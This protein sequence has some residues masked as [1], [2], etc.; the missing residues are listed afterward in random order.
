MICSVLFRFCFFNKSA[1]KSARLFLTA[2]LVFVLLFCISTPVVSAEKDTQVNSVDSVNLRDNQ[3][4]YSIYVAKNGNK[5]AAITRYDGGD[6]DIEIPSEL[7]GVPVK[8]ISRE[9]FCNGKYITSVA[10]PE[11]VTE[12]GKY[13]FS[14]CIGLSRVTFPESL[15]SV[16][17]GAF[18][19]CRSLKSA[20]FSE[21]L[22][23]IGSFAFYGCVHLTGAS[24]P[25]TLRSIGNSAFQGCCMLENVSFGSGLEIIGDTAFMGCASISG[26]DLSGINDLGAGAFTKCSA[27]KKVLLGENITELLPETFRN[28]SALETVKAG[29]GLSKIGVSAFEGCT[30][31]KKITGIEG[32]TEISSLAFK[33]CRSLKKFSIGD[34]VSVIG[35]GAFNGCTSLSQF[36]VSDANETYSA[37]CGCLCSKDI[38]KLIYCPQGFHGTLSLDAGV[39]EI[40]DYAA[41]GCS[42]ITKVVFDD[43]LRSIGRAAFLGCTDIAAFSLPENL[44][45]IERAAAGYYLSDGKAK[46]AEYVRIFAFKDTCAEKY[47]TERE[48][49][50]RY[51]DS[52]LCVSS[53]RVVLCR[54]DKFALTAEF[55]TKRR[56]DISWT[57]SDESVVTVSGGKLTAVSE[58][59]AEVTAS[60]DGFE[61]WVTEVVVISSEELGDSREK[62]FDSRL[63]YCGESEELSSLFS[64]II[65]PFFFSNKFWYS[66]SPAVATV[67]DDGRV[68]AH[69][70]GTA[71][72]TCHMPDGSENIVVVTVT[73]KPEQITITAPEGELLTGQSENLVKTLSPSFSSDS[74][75]WESD[76]ESI[77]TVDDK[78]RI[79]AVGHGKCSITAMTASGLK[80]SVDIHC[81]IPAESI[82][83]DKETRDVYQGKQFDLKATLVPESS[84]QKILWRSSDPNVASVNSK[85]R[86]TGKSFGSAVIYA[87]TSGGLK[88]ECR[89]N[90]LTHAEE[91][92]IDVKKLNINCGTSYKLNSII[93][94]SYSPETTDKCTWN[95]T[96][97]NVAVVDDSGLVTAVG[98][99]KCIIN[100]RAGGDLIS[101]CQVQVRLPAESLEI[102]AE[103]DSIYIGGTQSLEAV[104]TPAESTDRLEWFSDNE[105]VAYVTSGGTVKGKASGTAVITARLTN[106]VTGESV[107]ASFEIKVMKKA[108]SVT[109]IKKSLSM[110]IGEKD[111]ITFTLQPEDSNDTVRW[112]STDEKIAVVRHDG[113][114]TALAAG[115]CYICIETGSGVTAKCKLTVN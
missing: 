44:E 31:L 15:I 61:P 9:A 1:G 39:C 85:G 97:E 66:S 104:I 35:A 47:C 115:T 55:E 75:T 48:L 113:L 50:L 18:Y 102:R 19:G 80:S 77:A 79:T 20:E 76:D 63:I 84:D 7:G 89:V 94:P 108:E 45:K 112:Y 110:S 28:C 100:C 73:E 12:I 62:T 16:G 33:G 27:L 34:K 82:S 81:V 96:N 42:G 4:V 30:S 74:V 58:G 92:K 72:V 52:T 88:A 32:L 103:K 24:F 25:E 59:S 90:V 49:A 109:L 6:I 8:V 68:T 3:W 43:G 21:G 14:G 57:S 22:A 26:V 60:A 99:G 101:K 37:V 51:Y 2:A 106:D 40:S 93:R 5:Y 13:A 54:D 105:D 98:P 71:T 91:L 83:L 41:V 65:D 36:S 29:S 114:I 10:I 64:Q 87:E 11:G 38:T 70:R 23:K 46:K 78:G 53:E 107:T 86:V 69:G 67:D 95:T 111:F 17:D 56:G